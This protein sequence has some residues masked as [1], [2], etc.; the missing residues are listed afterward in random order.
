MGGQDIREA[1][2]SYILCGG[3][4]EYVHVCV[5]VPHLWCYGLYSYDI[6]LKNITIMTQKVIHVD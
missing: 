1:P 3:E 5:S 4:G 6:L 2:L